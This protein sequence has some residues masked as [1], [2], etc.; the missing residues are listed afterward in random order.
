MESM[1][2]LKYKLG[3]FLGKGS[4]KQN[5]KFYSKTSFLI[6]GKFY[7]IIIMLLREFCCLYIYK[8]KKD[9]HNNSRV[10]P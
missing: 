10:L 1:K 4:M 6:L 7:S 2:K 3:E 5:C 9:L 8:I